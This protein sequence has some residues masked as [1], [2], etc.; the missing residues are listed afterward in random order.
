MKWRRAR[1]SRRSVGTLPLTGDDQTAATHRELGQEDVEGGD[2]AR[3]ARGLG[4]AGGR[5]APSPR[6]RRPRA[7]PIVVPRSA[8][9]AREQ[10]ERA[11]QRDPLDL[12]ALAQEG[13]Q[14]IADDEGVGAQEV[15]RESGRIRQ[16]HPGEGG[17]RED[18]DPDLAD[19]DVRPEQVVGGSDDRLLERLGLE[20]AVQDD[21]AGARYEDDEGEERASNLEQSHA[22]I[23]P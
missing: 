22:P 10:D 18:R 17:A 13:P 20:V 7:Q 3:R 14:A 16:G 2:G 6:S 15:A 4:R 21:D 11:L 23:I 9:P 1:A 8:L 5:A 12:Q 19:L